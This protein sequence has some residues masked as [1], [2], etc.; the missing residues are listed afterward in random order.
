MVASATCRAPDSQTTH[1]E[2][3]SQGR[4]PAAETQ[5]VSIIYPRGPITGLPDAHASR[6]E[7][8]AELDDLQPGWQVELRSRDVGGAVD[9][10]FYSPAGENPKVDL[11]VPDCA[12]NLAGLALLSSYRPFHFA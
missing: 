10:A 1:Q 12:V 4:R 2:P 11:L 5:G 8:F 3:A 9:A 7:R 6:R